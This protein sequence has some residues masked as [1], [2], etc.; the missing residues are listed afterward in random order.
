L[1]NTWHILGAGSIGGL[2][3][4]HLS[5]ARQQVSLIL[6]D[7]QSGNQF[8][9]SSPRLSEGNA[10]YKPELHCGL[11]VNTDPI[12]KL[13]ITTKAPQTM[14]AFASI[15]HRLQSDS[16]IVILQNGIGIY[17]ELTP[18]HPAEH[19]YCAVSTEGAFQQQRYHWVHA[20][21]GET[22]IGQ[23]KLG[24]GIQPIQPLFETQLDCK[25]SNSI[26]QDQWKKLVINCAINGLTALHNCHNGELISNPDIHIKLQQ[27]CEEISMA[28]NVTEDF[29]LA[30]SIYEDTV[31]VIEAT[32]ENVSST[33]QDIQR[34]QKTE[35]E[36]ING[37]FCRL[38]EAQGINCQHN[39]RIWQQVME[40]E[41]K[42]NCR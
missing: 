14:I 1:S 30:N 8:R 24:A 7:K 34:G 21:H 32:A 33:L 13:L 27:L 23:P 37:Y 42:L 19:I 6:R 10:L 35:I 2:F 39:R 41:T 38:M 15:K 12:K 40:L 11:A 3:A 25:W 20:G 18:Y 16:A 5:L 31:K 26:A 9:Q 29:E 28:C 17:Q 36:Y 22:L 4:C